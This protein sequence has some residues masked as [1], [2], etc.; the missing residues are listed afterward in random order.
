MAEISGTITFGK[1]TKGKQR[2]V[3]NGKDG[4][5]YEEL[6]PKWR[7]VNVFEGEHVEKGEI[8]VDGEMNPHDILRLLGIT[9]LSEYLVKVTK[10]AWCRWA[11]KPLIGWTDTYLW[12]VQNY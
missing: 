3:I 5:T 11:K 10:N 8:I 1:D 2:L 4:E 6:I 7:H 9:A 12:D